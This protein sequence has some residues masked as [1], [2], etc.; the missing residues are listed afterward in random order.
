MRA[1]P[2]LLVLGCSAL[3]LLLAPA[4]DPQNG[5]TEEDGVVQEGDDVAA[6][7]V[8]LDGD[9]QPDAFD[10]DGDGVA[11]AIDSDGDGAPDA[12]DTD[13]DGELDDWD[14][15]GAADP[16]P[17]GV[18]DGDLANENDDADGY[19]FDPEA[20]WFECNDGAPAGTGVPGTPELGDPGLGGPPPTT[21]TGEGDLGDGDEGDDGD[22]DPPGNGGE[23]CDEEV[24]QAS[25][26]VPPRIL[27]V[28]D[29]SGSME[30]DAVG[31]PGSKWSGAVSALSS[32]VTS[33]SGEVDFGLMLYPDG[34]ADFNV[35]REGALEVGLSNDSA[36]DIVDE[37]EQAYPGGGTPTAATLEEAKDVLDGLP[38]S[39]GARVV[40]LATDGGP[41]CNESLDTD[42]CRCL[43]AGECTSSFNCLDDENTIAATAALTAAGYSVFVIG[44]PG[45]ENFSD[46]LND[47]ADAGGTALPGERSFYEANDADALAT[48]LENIASR[49]ATCRFDLDVAVAD[50]SDVTVTVGS[51]GVPHDPSRS[52]GWDLVDED[53]IELFGATCDALVGTP[54]NVQ[55][56]YCTDEGGL[57]G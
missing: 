46:V 28:V 49:V 26:A 42:S 5:V 53:T 48:S 57:G 8:D 35:C 13:G 16:L 34:N 29:K 54:A 52:N 18:D 7:P 32:V 51:A 45:S 6:V 30:E 12:Y 44:I 10:T 20:G 43:H 21:G 1:R 14:G 17:P 41:G 38:A 50:A 56:G 15:D 47:L 39:G 33:L 55:V 27:L 24:F 23:V 36:F 11:D 25:E 2:S 40:V 4:C 3:A 37:L 9:G 19:C 31:Y 22:D